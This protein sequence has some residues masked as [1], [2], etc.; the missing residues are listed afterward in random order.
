MLKCQKAYSRNHTNCGTK[1]EREKI[2]SCSK[3]WP[4]RAGVG[5]EAPQYTVECPPSQREISFLQRGIHYP[6]NFLDSVS[7]ERSLSKSLRECST[8]LIYLRAVLVENPP[9]PILSPFLNVLTPL[10][11]FSL[12]R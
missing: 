1:K 2:E 11:D 12:K 10:H 8:N 9:P 6:A 5:P 7:G 4:R 3:K